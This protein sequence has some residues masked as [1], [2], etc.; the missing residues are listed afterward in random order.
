M[1]Q[2]ALQ[3]MHRGRFR[4]SNVSPQA[5]LVFSIVGYESREVPVNGKTEISVILTEQVAQLNAVVIIGYGKQQRKEVTG[6]ISSI[7]AEEIQNIPSSSFENAIQGKVSGV[8]ISIP[9][10]E[11]GAAP[12]IRVRG[13][14]SVSAG[15]DPLYV[16]DGLPISKN[17]R[18]QANLGQRTTAFA[19]PT[20]NPFSTINPNDIKSIEILKDASSA[21][22]YGSRG[23]N[24]VV[25]ITT[26]KGQKG[27][28][29]VGLNMYRGVTSVF[30]K[31]DMMGSE[32][33]IKMT[34][35]SRNNHYL[36][37][38]NPLSPSSAYYNPNYNP[39]NNT[40]RQNTNDDFVMIPEKYINWDGTDTDWLDVIFSPGSTSNYNV[41]V[42]GR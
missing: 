2:L 17:T 29:R 12:T 14:G 28:T 22:I 34:K 32:D 15:S 39:D 42:S 3:R 10:G 13:T 38:Y 1:P 18:L 33:L 35:E 5:T 23:S 37:T 24:G 19:A 36:Q 31:P 30:N 9:S 7:T 26:N 4:L 21:G 8:E 11:P 40:G 41:N 25:L 20:I 6:A 16:I 27:K